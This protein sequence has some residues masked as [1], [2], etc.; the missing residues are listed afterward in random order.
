[1]EAMWTRFLPVTRQVR[2]WIEEQRIGQPRLLTADFGFRTGWTPEGRLLNL[3][4]AGGATLDVGV[5]V[6]ALASLVFGQPPAEIQAAAHIGET[7]VDEQTA[8]LLRYPGGA[9]ALLSCAV[10]TN[11]PQEARICGTDGSIHIPAFWHATSAT[12]AVTG[13]DPVETVGAAG[14][15]FETAEVMSCVREGRRESPLLPLDESLAIARALE[16]VRALI[17][18]TYPMERAVEP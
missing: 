7:G 4:L 8:M 9:L 2:T 3:K 12:L 5:Y 6:V 10:R 13:Q 1:M 16:Q 11:T 18:L 15:Q 14:F 17:G